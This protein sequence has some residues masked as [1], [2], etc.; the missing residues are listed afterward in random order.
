MNGS[1]SSSSCSKCRSDDLAADALRSG[2]DVGVSASAAKGFKALLGQREL[3]LDL[4]RADH[5]GRAERR[6][7]VDELVGR[8]EM[9]QLAG[10]D[11]PVES[12]PRLDVRVLPPDRI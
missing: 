3:P 6:H 1:V 11:Q 4:V 2:R 12:L 7:R 8:E 10:N 9:A 5:P